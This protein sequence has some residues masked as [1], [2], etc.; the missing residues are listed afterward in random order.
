MTTDAALVD[1][2]ALEAWWRAHLS[3]AGPLHLEPLGGGHSNAMFR[4][5]DGV[6]RWVLRRGPRVRTSATAHDVGR[7]HRVLTALRDTAVPHPRTLALCPDADV[8]GAP[9][10]VLEQVDGFAP[11]LPLPAPFTDDAAAQREMAFSLVDALAALASTDWRAIGLEGFGRPVGFLDRQVDRWLGA[12]EKVRTRSVPHLDEVAGWLRDRRPA[13][14]V[15]GLMHGDYTWNNVLFAPERPGRVAA[16]V[17]WEQSTIGD[18]LLDLGWLTGLWYEHGEDPQGRDPNTM[19]CLLPGLP[20]RVELVERYA[21]SSGLP[22]DDIAYYQVLALFK[23]TC[24]IESHWYRYQRGESADPT[25]ATFEIRVPVLAARAAAI[26][27]TG[28]PTD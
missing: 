28:S 17:D 2:P 26:A 14:P 18:P 22:V 25:H 6:D 23:L 15:T 21:G 27:A 20:T 10:L 12:L 8:I 13:H 16:I 4:V 3:A 24:I 19:F 7:E 11:G 9:F 1:L 5:T